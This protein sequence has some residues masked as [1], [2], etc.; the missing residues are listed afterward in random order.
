MSP[1]TRS[2]TL[3]AT[4]S[5]WW[6]RSARSARSSSATTGARRLPGTAALMRPDI[7]PAVVAMSVPHRRRGALPPLDTLR[8]AGQGRLLL[9]LFPGAGRRGRVR[10]RCGV[11]AAAHPLHRLGR[12]AA[13]RQ[14][15]HVCGPRARVFSG[16][17]RGAVSVAAVADA[18]QDIEMFAAEYR[19]TG[20]RGGLN[21]YRNIDRNWELTAPWQ[22]ATIMQP[23]LFIAGT[24]DAVITG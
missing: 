24:R 18:K 16:R 12:Y 15:E 14:D 3:S 7:F 17:S 2:C 22:D 1:P 5:R 20:F 8:K 19:R 10:A 6:R 21:W 11:H 13:R 23:A 9:A 4:W